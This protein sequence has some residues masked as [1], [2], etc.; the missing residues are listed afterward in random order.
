MCEVVLFLSLSFSPSP[1][2]VQTVELETEANL[3][4]IP[5][6]RHLEILGAGADMIF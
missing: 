6:H 4:Q 3:D 1:A 5:N 2:R